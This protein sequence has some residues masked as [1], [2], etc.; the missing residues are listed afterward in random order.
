MP[1]GPR[2]EIH[3]NP[4]YAPWLRNPVAKPM[5][6]ESMWRRRFEP[7]ASPGTRLCKSRCRGPDVVLLLDMTSNERVNGLI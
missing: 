7:K 6:E 5:P 4:L 3:E 1:T 2:V